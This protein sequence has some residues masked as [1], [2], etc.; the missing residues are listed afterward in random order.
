MWLN[1][2]AAEIIAVCDIRAL[3][4]VKRE[5]T[6][7]HGSIPA[8]ML[9]RCADQKRGGGNVQMIHRAVNPEVGSGDFLERIPAAEYP[10][11][12]IW[13]SPTTPP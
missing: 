10:W 9:N 13:S 7:V 11:A 6:E 5:L 4:V 3:A 2:A 8:G 1:A 12:G